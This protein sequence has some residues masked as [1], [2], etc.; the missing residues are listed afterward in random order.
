MKAKF[1]KCTCINSSLFLISIHKQKLSITDILKLK[2]KPIK[3]KQKSKQGDRIGTSN[4]YLVAQTLHSKGT[5]VSFV[6]T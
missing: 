3:D 6:D 4:K 2:K 5:I 1:T